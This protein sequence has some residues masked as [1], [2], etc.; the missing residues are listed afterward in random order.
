[1]E[2]MKNKTLDKE[3]TKVPGIH[4]VRLIGRLEN[5]FHCLQQWAAFI[6]EVGVTLHPLV[7]EKCHCKYF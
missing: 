7:P 3:K 6:G 5:I 4:S 1:M 2:L